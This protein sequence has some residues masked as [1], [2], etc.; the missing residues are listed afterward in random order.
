MKLYCLGTWRGMAAMS[1]FYICQ[2]LVCAGRTRPPA[3]FQNIPFRH[4]CSNFVHFPKFHAP[5]NTAHSMVSETCAQIMVENTTYFEHL[6]NHYILLKK[7]TL[8]IRYAHC[9]FSDM[10]WFDAITMQKIVVE[11]F[12]VMKKYKKTHGPSPNH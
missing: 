1:K 3:V 2:N 6:G 8:K 9:Q 12:W 5:P 11:R 7:Q 4:V 10:R